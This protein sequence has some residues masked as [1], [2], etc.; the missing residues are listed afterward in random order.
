MIIMTIHDFTTFM[1]PT[2]ATLYIRRNL[3]TNL[4]I[5]NYT[6]P[7]SHNIFHF[8]L[9]LLLNKIMGKVPQPRA[10]GENVNHHQPKLHSLENVHAS[11]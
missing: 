6:C 8:I 3:T 10:L 9:L 4:Q 5:L 11:Q 7:P 1:E 2:M